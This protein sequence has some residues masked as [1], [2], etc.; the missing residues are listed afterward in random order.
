M[1]GKSLDVD[2]WVMGYCWVL[3]QLLHDGKLS[4]ASLFFHT[5]QSQDI[6]STIKY[7]HLRYKN[8]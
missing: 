5:V 3:V 4:I 8:V 1:L 6:I 7:F 2:A